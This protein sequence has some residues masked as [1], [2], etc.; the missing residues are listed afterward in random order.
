[1]EQ[2]QNGK[3]EPFVEEIETIDIREISPNGWKLLE[4]AGVDVETLKAMANSAR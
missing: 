3:F 2:E 1:M 4:E